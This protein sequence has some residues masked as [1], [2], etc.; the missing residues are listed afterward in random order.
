VQIVPWADFRA[1]LI[2]VRSDERVW[3]ATANSDGDAYATNHTLLRS[4]CG[5]VMNAL[6]RDGIM[7]AR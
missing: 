2:D 6:V 3:V 5:Q 7:S 1:E 4:F